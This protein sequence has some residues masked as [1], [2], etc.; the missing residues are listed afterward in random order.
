LF[1]R[2]DVDAERPNLNPHTGRN[3]LLGARYSL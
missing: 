2:V 1:S 3:F